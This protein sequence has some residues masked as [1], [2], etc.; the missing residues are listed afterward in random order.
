MDLNNFQQWVDNLPAKSNEQIVADQKAKSNFML[1]HQRK[2]FSRDLSFQSDD[3]SQCSSVES[4]LESRKPD[5]EAI[6]LG[7]GFGPKTNN[8]ILS[9]IP[10]RFLQPS[11]VL[12]QIDINKFIERYA[13][14]QEE[15]ATIVGANFPRTNLPQTNSSCSLSSSSPAKT[16]PESK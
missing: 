3:G 1:Q 10:S 16:C 2:Y 13:E 15:E 8:S 7:L 12:K 6:L 9:R 4:V 14:S 5:P 11:Q